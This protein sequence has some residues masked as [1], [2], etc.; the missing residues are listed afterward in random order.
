MKSII[1]ISVYF[2]EFPY[3]FPLFVESANHNKSVKWIIFTD[4][5]WGKSFGE[6]EN[7]HI[8]EFDRYKF[9]K[10]AS[11]K[12]RQR[13]KIKTSY[14]L[15]DF[16]PSYGK[17]F[18]DYT[19]GYDF[20]GHTDIDVVWGDLRKF[21]TDDVLDGHDLITATGNSG[22]NRYVSGVFTIY[23]NTKKINNIYRSFHERYHEL[24]LSD[25][26]ETLDEV[27]IDFVLKNNP[28]LKVFMGFA[29]GGRHLPLI[30][31]GKKRT[32]AYWENGKLIVESYLNDYAGQK[33]FCGFGAE[34]LLFH[35]RE[36]TLKHYVNLETK[37]I[38]SVPDEAFYSLKSKHE[39]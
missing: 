33:S 29:C 9:E 21:L 3:Y 28:D 6:Q 30:R 12:L 16:K 10:L 14:K 20:W 32:P 25:K 34:S 5:G 39:S 36:K 27:S 1:L 4:K 35:V 38:E 13:I 37:R 7:V 17:I 18:E 24:I 19:A 26:Y 15:C 22:C 8:I 31:Y 2:G 11:T 23:K